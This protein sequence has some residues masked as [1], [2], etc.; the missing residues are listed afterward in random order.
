MYVCMYV[1]IRPI[2]TISVAKSHEYP[3]IV[4]LVFLHRKGLPRPRSL[5]YHHSL[6]GGFNAVEVLLKTWTGRGHRDT[7]ALSKSDFRLKKEGEGHY[8]SMLRDV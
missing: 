2:D 1:C 7:S 3:K 6:C 4:N 5:P 8:H